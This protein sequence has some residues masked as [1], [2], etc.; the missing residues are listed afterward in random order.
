MNPTT[1]EAAVEHALAAALAAQQ[2]GQ[3]VDLAALCGGRQDLAE[4]VAAALSLAA[5]LPA[6]QR[7]S[8][9]HDGWSG[10]L[11]GAR[12]RLGAIVGRGASGT[13]FAAR[14]ERLQRDVAVKLLHR[15]LFDGA[16]S[17]QR[18]LR[19]AVVLAAHNHPH[20]VQVYDQGQTDTGG[21]FL[22]TELL[23]GM[24]L[25][26]VLERAQQAIALPSAPAFARIEWL[27]QLLPHAQCESS[28]LRQAVRWIA[29]LGDAL[30]QAHALGIC[31][32]DVKPGNAFVTSTGRIVL[33]DFG[34]AA[35]A[36]DA[37]I[38]HANTLLGTPCY[39]APE[40]A[41]GQ[42]EPQP[43]L[44]VYGLGATLYHLLTHRPPHAGDLQTVLLA[45]RD[46]DP[47]PALRLHPGLARDLQA[48]LDRALAKL[49][50]HRYPTMA[51]FTADLRAFLNHLPVTARPLGRLQ[52]A[53][54]Q[55]AR[56]PARSAA[57]LGAAT[58]VLVFAAAWP[59]FA[60]VSA[61][62]RATARS[63]LLRRLPADLCIEGRPEVLALAPLDER[64]TGLAELDRLLELD[65]E[66]VAFRVLRGTCWLDSGDLGRAR[67]DF[68]AALRTAPGPYLHAL[69][70][71][72]RQATS[73][74]GVGAV[75]LNDLP[76]PV[77]DADCFLAGLHALRRNQ[78]E[79]ADQ[80]LTRCE[81]YLPARD[82]RLLAIL[83]RQPTQPQR[84]FGEAQQLEAI[85]GHPTA[86]TQHAMGAA[87]LQ[88]RDYAA[89]IPF[90][91]H[92]LRLRPDRHGPWNNLGLAHLRLGDLDRALD[93]YGKAVAQKPWLDNSL[94]GLCQVLRR[95]DRTDE[96]CAA[97]VR[98]RDVGWR[99]HELGHVQLGIALAAERRG[100]A[101]ARIAAARQAAQH[102]AAAAAETATKN[103][104]AA[105]VPVALRLAQALGQT[106][107]HSA[108]LPFLAELRNEPRNA[109][110]IANLASL[111]AG[112]ELTDAVVAR[113]RL[114]LLDLAI[115]LAPQD[116]TFRS[117]RERLLESL[118]TPR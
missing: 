35:R 50:Q 104:R 76:E 91:E 31:H 20:I 79:H 45:L 66:D 105:G 11:L 3:P 9:D 84:A 90:C 7:T 106:E 26:A 74:D 83:G 33:L 102:L 85:Y 111:L 65:G 89:A 103:P 82:L 12:Y 87:M 22:V 108:L 113:L 28:Y 78:C 18:F 73:R 109:R 67:A 112:A 10:T 68:T 62:A 59:A 14:D 99:E 118:R 32:R 37:T 52:R 70:D 69:V 61:Q 51:A 13:V 96:A 25:H 86:R 57:M 34:I 38:T 47:V 4:Q 54:R 19:E 30:A 116:P 93:C 60:A 75:D 88:L 49:P 80:L 1:D 17:A 24:S 27:Q 115:D 110:Q 56:R 23:T 77:G 8:S 94:S 81:H 92:S 71:R 41:R 63:E 16:V 72:Y 107:V 42:P 117:D 39:M 21:T 48:V 2:A 53:W 40:Q 64:R 6:M 15:G 95:L 5:A 58:T 114:W 97:A 98:M 46:V 100:D 55:A 43:T 29:D 101:A 36:G 44:D